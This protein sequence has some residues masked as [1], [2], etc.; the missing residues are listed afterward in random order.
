MQ[1]T[2][3]TQTTDTPDESAMWL[4]AKGKTLEQLVTEDVHS[5]SLI[6]GIH[7]KIPVT[8][9][10]PC[11]CGKDTC[12]PVAVA[13]DTQ[14]VYI[15]VA[16]G[17]GSRVLSAATHKAFNKDAMVEAFIASLLGS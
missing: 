7:V 6:R 8:Q 3:T 1:D 12:P 17:P 4:E 2:Q 16:T 9:T 14:E 5:G 15:S 11:K 13:G 10:V